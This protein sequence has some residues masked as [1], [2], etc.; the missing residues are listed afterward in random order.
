MVIIDVPIA[1][2]A[3][4]D[5]DPDPCLVS[6]SRTHLK[7]TNH[8]QLLQVSVPLIANACPE[9]RPELTMYG[10]VGCPEGSDRL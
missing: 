4:Y 2:Q 3:R 8:A 10:E 5:P 7:W 1:R 6:I 9:H